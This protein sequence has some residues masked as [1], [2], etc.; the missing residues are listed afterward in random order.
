[1][2]TLGKI[3]KFGNRCI[4]VVAFL[5]MFILLLMGGYT[6]WDIYQLHQNAYISSDLLKYKPPVDAEDNLSLL[7]LKAINDDIC[8]WITIDDTHIDYPFAQGED[9]MEYVNKD[10]EGNYTMSGAIFLS[11]KNNK[12]LSD[13]YNLT[14]GHHMENG[15]MYGDVTEFLDQ[16]YFDSHRTGYIQI[17]EATYKLEVFG[18]VECETSNAMIYQPN[19]YT[20][21]S[22]V[23]LDD[24]VRAN[25]EH[26]RDVGIKENDQI[27][28]LSTCHDTLSN[29]R[30]VLFA[31]MIREE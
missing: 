26:Y 31:K 18:I 27:V 16:S 28:S 6:L 19:N 22:I 21:Q 17:P 11:Y 10:I 4:D 13:P 15:A 9:D 5:C 30:I 20:S 24:Y 7:E 8:G 14:Y 1:M 3:A 2:N 23:R 25:A 12:D 29:G